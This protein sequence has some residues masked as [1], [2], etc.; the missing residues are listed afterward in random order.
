MKTITLDDLLAAEGLTTVD[1]MSMDIELS[2]PA[3]L[4]GLDLARARPSLVCIE[5]HYDVRQ[6]ILDYFASRGYRLLARYLRAD[7]ANLYFAP[8]DARW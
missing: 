4:A 5:A 8:I 1:F 3:A 2:E 6:A 7:R